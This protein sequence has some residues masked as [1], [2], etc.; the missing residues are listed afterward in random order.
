MCVCA[1]A[2]ACAYIESGGGADELGV[3]VDSRITPTITPTVGRDAQLLTI[4]CKLCLERSDTLLHVAWGNEGGRE[5][6]RRWREKVRGRKAG[7]YG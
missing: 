6:E 2:C 5:K 7:M 3:D 1:C 4:A